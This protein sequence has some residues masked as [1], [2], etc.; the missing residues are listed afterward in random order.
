MCD[1]L[2]KNDL[3]AVCENVCNVFEAAW[4]ENIAQQ[5]RTL[6][7]MG[8]LCTQLS[9]SGPSVFGIFE[10]GKGSLAAEKLCRQF[11]YVSL[12]TPTNCGCKI[13][14]TE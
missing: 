2:A 10:S 9:G 14:K 11:E 3:G 8:A 5:K 13:I 1:A 6:L 7:D 12:C 4:G